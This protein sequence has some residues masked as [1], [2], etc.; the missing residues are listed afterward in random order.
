MALHVIFS[1]KQWEE[2]MLRFAVVT[3]QLRFTHSC[4]CSKWWLWTVK[5]QKKNEYFIPLLLHHEKIKQKVKIHTLHLINIRSAEEV[6]QTSLDVTRYRCLV[7]H[8]FAWVWTR[9]VHLNTERLKKLRCHNTLKHKPYNG[10][11]QKFCMYKSHWER[12]IRYDLKLK[13]SYYRSWGKLHWCQHVSAPTFRWTKISRSQNVSAPKRRGFI[14]SR[15]KY[16]SIYIY[17]YIYTYIYIYIYIFDLFMQLCFLETFWSFFSKS[18]KHAFVWRLVSL[19]TM[20]E[21]Q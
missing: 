8:S 12:A 20:K 10:R 3:L 21:H 1:P 18:R 19:R 9:G 7:V 2:A 11:C 17:I 15:C 14:T 4:C 13:N 16:K 6:L 5:K